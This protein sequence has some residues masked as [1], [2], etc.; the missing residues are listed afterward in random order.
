M[1]LNRKRYT[2]VNPTVRKDRAE[3][4]GELTGISCPTPNLNTRDMHA[5]ITCMYKALK[6]NNKGGKAIIAYKDRKCANGVRKI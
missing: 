6:E 1:T 5:E 3:T 2:D 4:S